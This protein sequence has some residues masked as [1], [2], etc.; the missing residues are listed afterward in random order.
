MGRNGQQRGTE[1]G[2]HTTGKSTQVLGTESD[3][4]NKREKTEIED[5]IMTRGKS[6]IKRENLSKEQG[7]LG[8]KFS[9]CTGK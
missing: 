3:K 7:T 4:G 2:E 8:N 6:V 1:K 5:L 9:Q